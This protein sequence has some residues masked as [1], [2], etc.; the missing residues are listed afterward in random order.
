MYIREYDTVHSMI[1]CIFIVFQNYS[2]YC[3][4]FEIILLDL[5]RKNVD[6]SHINC[7]IG[8]VHHLQ[9]NIDM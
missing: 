1:I 4:L 9:I 3:C 6:H 7:V 5:I 8:D 2:D